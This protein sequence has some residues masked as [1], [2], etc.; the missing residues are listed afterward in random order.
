LIENSPSQNP[1]MK[2]KTYLNTA[3]QRVTTTQAH[4]KRKA[5]M[6]PT[7]NSQTVNSQKAR[8]E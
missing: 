2:P 3:G 6:N 5:A 4:R 1:R 8:Y 7:A